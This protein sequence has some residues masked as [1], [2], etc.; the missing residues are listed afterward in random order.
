MFLHHFEVKLYQPVE[1]YLFVWQFRHVFDEIQQEVFKVSAVDNE[2]PEELIR[3][4]EG[5]NR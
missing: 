5:D 3:F 2:Q 4:F 1:D